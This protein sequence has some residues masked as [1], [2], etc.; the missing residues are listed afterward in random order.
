[1]QCRCG[2]IDV[3]SPFKVNQFGQVIFFGKFTSFD[4]C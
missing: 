2:S 1:V 4:A 3:V